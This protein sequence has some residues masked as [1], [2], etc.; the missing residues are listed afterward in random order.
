[1][2]DI[3]ATLFGD[4]LAIRRRAMGSHESAVG[5]KDEWLTPRSLIESLGTFDLD[6]CSPINR[7]W[8]TAAKHYTI[9]DDGLAQPWHGRVWMN[10]PYAHVGKWLH[11]LAE[12]GTGTA[13]IFARTETGVWF[14]HVW[15]RAAGVL[16]IKGRLAF[17]HVDGRRADS[18][19]GAPSALIAYGEADAEVLASGVVEGAYVTPRRAAS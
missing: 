1:M 2:N 12:H 13:L 9:E 16:F 17:H 8:P 7:P 15:P 5:G 10:P 6:P 4:A 18:S 14:N 11:R 19:A 3:E